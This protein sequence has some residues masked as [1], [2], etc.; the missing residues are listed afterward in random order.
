[1]IKTDGKIEWIGSKMGGKGGPKG[2]KSAYR[3]AVSF[4]HLKSQTKLTIALLH[5]AECANFY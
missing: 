3:V 5:H 4:I 1:M 2:A